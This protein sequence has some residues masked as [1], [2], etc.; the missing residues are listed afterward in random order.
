MYRMR[1]GTAEIAALF[2][3]EVPAGANVPDEMYPGYPGLV[4]NGSDIRV[5]TW[6]FPLV[7]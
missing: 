7:L 3:A 1:A 5:M 4:T 2:G 6:G